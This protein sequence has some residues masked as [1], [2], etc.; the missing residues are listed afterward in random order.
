MKNNTNKVYINDFNLLITNQIN[1]SGERK[2]GVVTKRENRLLKIGFL[3]QAEVIAFHVFDGKH[4]HNF[5]VVGHWKMPHFPLFYEGARLGNGLIFVDTAFDVRHQRG[6]L[7]RFSVAL[8][9]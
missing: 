2:Q 6:N 3:M 5:V 7:D 4:P 9:F 1:R 8:S